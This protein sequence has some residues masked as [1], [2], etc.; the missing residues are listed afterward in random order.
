VLVVVL[1]LSGV[2]QAAM[3]VERGVAAVVN[4]RRAREGVNVTAQRFV[5]DEAD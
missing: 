2:R 1:M 4:C 3:V 5:T